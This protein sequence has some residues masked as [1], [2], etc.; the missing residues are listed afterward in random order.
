MAKLY[1]GRLSGHSYKIRLFLSLIGLSYE[2]S[3]IDIKQGENK[4]AS[5]LSINPLGQVP[6]W[7]DGE[8]IIRDSQAILV[9]LAQ[10]YAQG[11]W[12]L[13]SDAAELAEIVQWLSFAANEISNSVVP[14]RRAYL[15]RK[16]DVFPP[17]VNLPLITEKTHRVL[18]ILN[19]HLANREWLAL[20]HASIAD[21]ACFAYIALIE[22]EIPFPLDAYPHVKQ[23]VQRIQSLNGFIPL[24]PAT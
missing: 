1:Y 3:L 15:Y 20:Q 9:Y 22:Q 10:Q 21:I 23:W 6:V 7:Q 14:L 12:K 17:D 4:T 11:V 2:P 13:P 5:Y 16:N 8:L 19:D 24:V 18:G